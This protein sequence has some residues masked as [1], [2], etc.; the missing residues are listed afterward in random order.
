MSVGGGEGPEGVIVPLP[1]V[2]SS[3]VGAG[4][5]RRGHVEVRVSEGLSVAPSA[6]ACGSRVENVVSCIFFFVT[7]RLFFFFFFLRVRLG[8][9]GCIVLSLLCVCLYFCFFG[10]FLCFRMCRG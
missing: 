8:E 10:L 3:A 4:K 9:G 5:R 2:W 1:K 6:L 7:D